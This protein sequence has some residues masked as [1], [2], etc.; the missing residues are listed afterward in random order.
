[1]AEDDTEKS[2]EP[3]PKKLE[4]ARKKGEIARSTDLNTAV[5]YAG[6]LLGCLTLAPWGLQ[7]I[8]SGLAGLITH[9]EPLSMHL[10]SGDG[11]QLAEVLSSIFIGAA[12]FIAIPAFCVLSALIAQRTIIV[13]PSKVKPKASRISILSNAKQKFGRAGLF[14]FAKSF[15]KLVIYSVL[16]GFL[17]IG[18][19]SQLVALAGYE[20]S[21][22][23]LALF[24]LM[25]SF[26]TQIVLVA[27]VIGVLD[28]MFQR[29][30]HTRKN[31]MSFKELQDEQKNAEGDPH[32]KQQRRQRGYEIAM[33]QMM[34][35]VEDADVVVMNPTHFAVA[36]KWDRLSG[37]AP[38]CVAKGRD[39][40]AL[41]IR[42][43]AMEHGVA[44][45]HDPPT[46]RALHASLEIGDEISPEHYKPVA[47]AI[48]FA[49][50]LRTMQR[51]SS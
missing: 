49:E 14:E 29:A 33:S 3:T 44:V 19:A 5:A 43:R 50:K 9:A 22:I 28:L 23:V 24:G 42:D 18:G 41:A 38:I 15:I 13:T 36:L 4:E 35:D 40:V 31:R 32:M 34:K 6:F 2:H 11:G 46:A 39:H 30:E 16:L 17:L 27:V 45:R 20:P 51:P 8:S 47:A 37:R 7:K 48:R 10:A 26:V 1:M 21:G 25:R 12:P